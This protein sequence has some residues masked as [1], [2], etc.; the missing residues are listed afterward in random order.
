MNKYMN[1]VNLF[2]PVY[3]DHVV[4]WIAECCGES[5]IFSRNLSNGVSSLAGCVLVADI[6]G[7]FDCGRFC[8]WGFWAK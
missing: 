4:N 6:Y 3:V 5:F 1:E 7:A 2:F 8:S